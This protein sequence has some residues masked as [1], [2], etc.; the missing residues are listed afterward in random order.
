MPRTPLLSDLTARARTTAHARTRPCPC[1]ATTT[2]TDRPDGTVV[3]HEDTV[4]KAHAP[5]TDPTDLTARLTT[6]AHLP[7]ILLPPLDPTPS[8]CTTAW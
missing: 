7:G 1:G 3:R 4:A 8:T 6:A 5:H 2:L